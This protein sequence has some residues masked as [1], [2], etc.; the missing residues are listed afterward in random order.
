MG[1]WVTFD[2]GCIPSNEKVLQY[3]YSYVSKLK[4]SI[5]L[6]EDIHNEKHFEETCLPCAGPDSGFRP[7]RIGRDDK[8]RHDRYAVI[9]VGG[10]IPGDTGQLG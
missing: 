4:N 8:Y 10:Y 6:K 2:E 5:T 1:L 9:A 7:V 3:D